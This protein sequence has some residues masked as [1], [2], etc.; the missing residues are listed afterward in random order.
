M[1]KPELLV[2]PQNLLSH[3]IRC[4]EVCRVVRNDFNIRFLSSSTYKHLVDEYDFHSIEW[5]SDS[6]HRIINEVSNFDFSW[7]NYSDQKISIEK[8]IELFKTCKPDFV[9]GDAIPELKIA[10]ESAKIPFIAIMNA[11][12][13]RYYTDIRP[14]P[15]HHK[16]QKYSKYFSPGAWNSFIR[17]A[18]KIAL[19]YYHKPL[20]KIRREYKLNKTQN[21]LDEFSGDI[22]LICDNMILFPLKKIIPG[23]HVI[24]P[25]FYRSHRKDSELKQWLEVRL[26]RPTLFVS[27]GSSS[28]EWNVEIFK[29]SF[30]S[31]YN[32][33]IA[34][35][36]DILNED[37]IFARPFINVNE[38]IKNISL[39]ICH[40]GN[41]TIYQALYHAIPVIIIPSIFEHEWNAYRIKKL[42]LGSIYYKNEPQE[43]LYDL[44]I[45]HICEGQTTE[46]KNISAVLQSENFEKQVYSAFNCTSKML[47]NSKVIS[48]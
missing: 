3:Y 1:L 24:G 7:I 19:T 39:F 48:K 21:L 8:F 28:R 17:L 42:N 15:H 26:F 38:I 2:C 22:T 33:I 14:L 45:K 35:V 36:K 34:G 4:L 11:Y 5:E 6:I 12:M 29:N 46:L 41:G 10:T 25:L 44:V 23:Y 47:Q 27:M 13:S 43:K 40:G 16:A 37:H 18:E 31:E 20:A 9:M 32:I 30:F